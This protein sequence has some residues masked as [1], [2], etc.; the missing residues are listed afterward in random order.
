[1]F[2]T[3]TNWI[4]LIREGCIRT[5]YT[6]NNGYVEVFEWENLLGFW[7][8]NT[9]FTYFYLG[10]FRVSG[11]WINVQKN[12]SG[13]ELPINIWMIE[14]PFGDFHEAGCA[15]QQGPIESIT[16]LYLWFLRHRDRF[17]YELIHRIYHHRWILCACVL[18]KCSTSG[19]NQNCIERQRHNREWQKLKKKFLLVA[20]LNIN[21]C[22]YV[23]LLCMI[24]I[25][26]IWMTSI[27]K[28]WEKKCAV[29]E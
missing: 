15:L 24:V 2:G 9:H 29:F 28:R 21:I 20:Y 10:P 22:I 5:Y 26:I 7:I 18:S 8:I 3:W 23:Y 17:A 14:E 4:D 1:M 11:F 12:Y 19:I 13:M 16:D 27:A 6:C 25:I